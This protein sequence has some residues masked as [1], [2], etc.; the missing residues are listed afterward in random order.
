MQTGDFV[1]WMAQAE[2]ILGSFGTVLFRHSLATALG[3]DIL[4][5]VTQ[6]TR[7]IRVVDILEAMTLSRLL[8]ATD[9]RD[10][11]YALLPLIDDRRIGNIVIDYSLSVS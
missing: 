3:P 10:H 7:K 5:D 4:V 1:L 2:N 6:H 8:E 11:L 9:S